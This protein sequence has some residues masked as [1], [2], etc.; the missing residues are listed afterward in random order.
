MLSKIIFSI[1]LEL[2]KI[3]VKRVDNKLNDATVESLKESF[4]GE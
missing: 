2:V 1:A 3:L 4:K